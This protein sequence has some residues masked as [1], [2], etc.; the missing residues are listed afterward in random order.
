MTSAQR[1]TRLERALGE[2]AHQFHGPHGMPS[3]RHQAPALAELLAEYLAGTS[4][5]DDSF[6]GRETTEAL[7]AEEHR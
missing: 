4:P 2:F 1:L 7:A 5:R 3:L 6:V